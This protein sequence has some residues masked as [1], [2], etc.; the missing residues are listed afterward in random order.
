MSVFMGGLP[1]SNPRKNVWK[2]RFPNPLLVRFC[3]HVSYLY[4]LSDFR[5]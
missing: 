4:T 1:G 5:I 3:P 2:K